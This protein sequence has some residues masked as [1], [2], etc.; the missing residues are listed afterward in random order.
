MTD[1]ERREGNTEA[2]KVDEREVR[3][4]GNHESGP[5]RAATFKQIQRTS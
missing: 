1:R 3:A 4:N 2:P 5:R